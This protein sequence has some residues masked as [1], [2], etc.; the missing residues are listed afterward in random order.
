M[1]ELAIGDRAE[2]KG[3]LLEA[4]GRRQAVLLRS[5]AREHRGREPHRDC[6][7]K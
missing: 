6:L 2:G 7:M 1:S 4:D 3:G 5:M